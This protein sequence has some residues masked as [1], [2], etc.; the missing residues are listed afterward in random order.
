LLSYASDLGVLVEAVQNSRPQ[1]VTLAK[2]SKGVLTQVSEE[3]QRTLYTVRNQEDAVRILVI[4]HPAR[5]GWRLK[6]DAT[7]PEEKAPGTYRFRVSLAANASATLPIEEVR[8]VSTTFQIADLGPDQ[9]QLFL[10]NGSVTSEMA[11]ALQ[12]IATQKAVVE[13]LEQEMEDRQKDIDRIVDDQGRLRENMKALRGSAEEKALLQRYTKQLDDQETQLAN[14]R[15]KIQDT[16]AQRDAAQSQ[17]E[18][19]IA[20]LQLEASF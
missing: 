7:Q 18:Q 9:V 13:K 3:E 15:K 20:G 2:I 12:K 8:P 5:P 11:A 4:E 14:L 6:K 19:M 1:H 17:L 16:E 10:K